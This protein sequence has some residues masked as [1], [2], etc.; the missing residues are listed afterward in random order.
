[1]RCGNPANVKALSINALVMA[2]AAQRRALMISSQSD[3]VASLPSARVADL[4]APAPPRSR[5][6]IMEEPDQHD[7]V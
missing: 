3:N 7:D 4:R 1:M 2:H 5:R 6:T